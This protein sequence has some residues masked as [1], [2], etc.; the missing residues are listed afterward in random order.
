MAKAQFYIEL[1]TAEDPE[2]IVQRD[3]RRYRG[4][5][6]RHGARRLPH[7]RQCRPTPTTPSAHCLGRGN[8]A[9][10]A[11]PQGSRAPGATLFQ[12]WYLTKST[13]GSRGTSPRPLAASCRPSPRRIKP[14]S[15]PTC[16]RLPAS[17]TSTF[18]CANCRNNSGPPPRLCYSTQ[19]L[20]L[21]KLPICWPAR[22]F[23]IQRANTPAKCCNSPAMLA[24][25]LSVP[26]G[27][28]HPLSAPLHLP[29][30][31]GPTP[32]RAPAA[33]RW[34]H[35]HRRRLGGAALQP[36]L[37]PRQDTRPTGR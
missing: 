34:C 14:S 23:R 37:S 27:S 18:Q 13:L 35:R 19:R 15:S 3:G 22:P 6:T 30:T 9:R 29:R 36:S 5:R 11:R 10:D 12:P 1:A 8:F 25:F 7:F 28:A 2:G 31:G 26:A 17:P 4:G 21:R 20:A 16:R 32:S 24:N 33:P